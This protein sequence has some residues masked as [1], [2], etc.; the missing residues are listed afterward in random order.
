M[1][2]RD[3]TP[4]SSWNNTRC[5]TETFG[6]DYIA[7]PVNGNVFQISWPWH[8]YGNPALYMSHPRERGL[9]LVHAIEYANK[10]TVPSLTHPNVYLM[11]GVQD[12]STTAL[13]ERTLASAS[14]T[15]QVEGEINRR[16]PIAY[17]TSTALE[18]DA[19]D[20]T[21]EMLMAIKL[22]RV[23][24]S[25]SSE[26]EIMLNAATTANDNA[27]GILVTGVLNPTLT[28]PDLVTFSY[29]NT[30]SC[31]QVWKASTNAL[32]AFSGGSHLFAIA[33]GPNS[34]NSVDL[35]PQKIILSPNDVLL[36]TFSQVDSGVGNFTIT[37]TWVED[38]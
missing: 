22:P 26:C 8:G 34:S 17:V 6:G 28:D 35:T 16:T 33:T 30:E 13:A 11:W 32:T 4:R 19:A 38:Q 25:Q 24:A 21:K 5:D 20:G 2:S 29:V 1:Q 12:V 15:L 36:F 9:K 37:V 23:F 14:G 31:V 3:F 27:K 18:P 10:Y 7:D